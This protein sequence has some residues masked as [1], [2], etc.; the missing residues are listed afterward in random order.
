MLVDELE[1]SICVAETISC[2]YVCVHPHTRGQIHTR[3]HTHTTLFS[4]ITYIPL[5]RYTNGDEYHGDWKAGMRHGYGYM[6]ETSQAGSRYSGNWSNDQYHGYGIYD[7]KM[8]YHTLS[9]HINYNK[10]LILSYR[11]YRYLGMFQSHC[12]HG[13]GII[14]TSTGTYCEAIFAANKIVESHDSLLMDPN[15]RSFLGK[16]GGYFQ[17]LGK[18]IM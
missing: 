5:N 7:D 6:L 13:A 4:N 10:H 17:L 12:Y 1:H 14:I 9:N 18:V 15:G 3:M 2:T 8:R 11:H 16:V